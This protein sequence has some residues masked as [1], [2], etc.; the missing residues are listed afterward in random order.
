MNHRFEGLIAVLALIHA[1]SG[2]STGGGGTEVALLTAE[3]VESP[4]G[5]ARPVAVHAADLNGDSLMDLVSVWSDSNE[6]RLHIL[7]SVDPIRFTQS[8][9]TG[10]LDVTI[11]SP[12][13]MAIGDVDEDGRPDMIVA[14]S[15]GRIVYLRS[16]QNPARGQDWEVFEIAE[17]FGDGIG[18]WRHVG[19]ADIDSMDG[20]DIVASG[21]GR[22]AWIRNPGLAAAGTNWRRVDL[23]TQNRAG[24]SH[25]LETDLDGDE[26]IDVI[27]AAPGES[28]E[29]LVW[30]EN[31]LSSAGDPF[32]E[33][34]WRRRVIGTVVGAERIALTPIDQDDRP[35]LLASSAEERRVTALLQPTNLRSDNPWI[36][37]AIVVEFL[38]NRP[39]DVQAGD[40][41]GDEAVEIITSTRELGTV[42]FFD[43]PSNPLSFWMEE[44]ILDT[45]PEDAAVG[46]MAVSDVD[47]DGR[48]DIAVPLDAAS[49]DSIVLLRSGAR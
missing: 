42:R 14:Q 44:F 7:E 27:S 31:P 35:D 28:S 12:Q 19:L 48:L 17:S 38:S 9:I 13:A 23:D 15:D 2:C 22:V 25:S 11:V 1:L 46:V 30:Y 20:I 29:Q 33:T 8:Q 36:D 40:I 5:S 26:D 37:T 18:A 43:R 34:Q 24:A 47:G 3:L 16:P 41:D 6:I 45:L 4:S 21:D 32:I 49:E 10:D 39:Q